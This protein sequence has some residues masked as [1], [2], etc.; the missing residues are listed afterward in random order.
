M[1][2][3]VL[4]S[5]FATLSSVRMSTVKQTMPDSCARMLSTGGKKFCCPTHKTM[6]MVVS[7][8]AIEEY[9]E[10]ADYLSM[11]LTCSPEFL[12]TTQDV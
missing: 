1:G 9:T 8:Q 12:R 6:E 2:F 11:M 3:Y 5:I 10:R 7:V 4:L